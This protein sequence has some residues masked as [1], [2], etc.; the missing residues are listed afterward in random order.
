MKRVR[1]S[2]RGASPLHLLTALSLIALSGLAF[3]KHSGPPPDP[4]Q[5]LRPPEAQQS[6]IVRGY[7]AAAVPVPANTQ[8]DP[9]SR[10]KPVRPDTSGIAGR[11]RGDDRRAAR[12]DARTDPPAELKDIYLP[13]VS[14]FLEDP[15]A[16][17]R[18]EAG[19]TDLSG[20]FTLYA[21]APGRYRLCWKSGVYGDG[22]T[23]DLVSAGSESRFLSTVRIQLPPQ[24]DFV[25][26]SGRVTT[27]DGSTP[28]VFDPLLNINAFATVSLWDARAERVASVYVNNFGDYLIPHVPARQK[29]KLTAAIESAGS[30]RELWPE[31]RLE[32]APFHRLDLKIENR[33]PRLDPLVAFDAS[34]RRVQNAAPGSRINVR[35]NVRDDDG[36]PVSYTWFVEPGGGGLSSTTES[37]TL[38][39]LPDTPGRHNITVV[40]R[41]GK[42]GYDKSVLS[43]LVGNRGV[44]FTG[45]V[46]EPGGA[47][48]GNA[49]VE[50]VGNPAVETGPDGY[51]SAVVAEA[52]RYVFNVR[53]RGYALNSQIYDR[54]VTGGR[55]LL[56]PAK[57]VIIDPTREAV[58]NHER[59]QRDCPGPD[60]A[61]AGSG[62][63][64]DS[65]SEPQWQD[66]QG[67]A[68]DRPGGGADEFLA[69][70]GRCCRRKGRVSVTKFQRRD[71]QAER[72]PAVIPRTLQLRPCGPGVGVRIPAN[73][74]LDASGNPATAPFEAAISTVDLL[75][76]QQMPG[77]GS[78]Q[79][80]SGGG[81]LESFG[82]GALDLPPGFKLRD[83]ARATVTIPVD[84]S[85]LM[86]GPLP[87][88]VPFLTYDEVKGLWV[89]EGS[90]TLTTVAGAQSY[91]AT[92][93]HFSSFNAD[94]VFSNASCL[95]VFSQSLPGQYNLEVSA[96][97]GGT[98]APY[99]V[100]KPVDNTSSQEHV[101][102]NLPNNANVTL[103]PMTQGP[104]P[105]LL[106]YYVVNSGPP[107][108]PNNSPGVPPGP[109]YTSCQN[110]V[111]LKAGSAPDTP[112]GGEFL[113]GLGNVAG[114]NLG[115]DDL[116][117]ADP[118]GNALR[119]AIVAASR[120]YYSSVD[121]SN[122]R[123]TFDAFKTLHGFNLDP[124]GATPGEIVA[125]YANS[126]DLG[127]GRD[128]HCLKKAGG[129]VACYVTNYGTG[130]VNSHPGIGTSDQ[131]DAAA[132]AARATVGNSAEVATV[133]MEYSP[134][135]GAG[136]AKVVKFFVYK[137]GFPNAG[138]YERSISANLDGRGE[139]P[140]PQLCMI[141]HGGAIPSH[142]GG[143]PAFG[144]ATQVNLNARFVPFDHRLFTFPASPS[145]AAQEASIKA[146]NE[147][148]V[149]AAP[150]APSGDAIKEVVAGL[151]NNGAASQQILNF[152]VPGWQTGASANL[153]NQSD[154]YQKVVANGCRTC[155][156]AQPFD[157]L[158]FNTSA[159]FLR[160]VDIG[161]PN[162]NLMLGTA[163]LR[164]CGDY[165]MPHAFRTHE[166][167]WQKYTAID[168]TLLQ[169]LMPER[170]Q[171][172]GDGVPN[173][174]TGP[175]QQ[176]NWKA[177][178]C[179][180]FVSNLAA[181]PSNF[182]QQSI[183]PIFNGKCIYCHAGGFPA[184]GLN[185]SE[186]SPPDSP[187][188][189]WQQLLDGRVVPGNDNG[190]LLVQRITATGGTRMPPG[191]WR[192]PEKPPDPPNGSLPCLL[193]PDVDRI[194]AWI[195]SGAN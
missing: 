31:A 179:T 36:D 178:L 162:N 110:F 148:I 176:R 163:Q 50:I 136:P 168:P 115:F 62:A 165:T 102:Y 146:L 101:I 5:T 20:R 67:R 164:A 144:N 78:V 174:F 96:P 35:S 49:R 154:F 192:A 1:L 44:P 59:G 145:K 195:R 60:S 82:A 194:K 57:I 122:L 58:I 119:D 23:D 14:V 170:L 189:S 184:G 7:L 160:R 24:K 190:S 153:P 134:I 156:T 99:V 135:E 86:G 158:K 185:L 140:V 124:N 118:T 53:K 55:W 143:V 69:T 132:A 28:R 52:D 42:G 111:V 30:S 131:D 137:K 167:F 10:R 166:I 95:R 64:G 133:A 65:I 74:I 12:T 73:S 29:I 172:F 98:G 26:M 103:A 19:Q 17:L 157:Q 33:R 100:T 47:P 51:F 130:Y 191:C 2:Q 161:D 138:S 63:A 41:D 83:G 149:D 66:G 150:P 85:R 186:A 187:Q 71:E 123:T 180:S 11:R 112:F 43:V 68:V 104:N 4:A 9:D 13:G 21:P 27:A 126:G 40:A 16:S 25:L 56:H 22:C 87:P 139:R 121:P 89:E 70:G 80:A 15:Q 81:R 128:M 129:D 105:Q 169:F 8:R 39:T 90:M 155:H 92:T 18:S 91:V 171:S 107:Q 32:R 88:A 183:Q 61:A 116:T 72:P 181:Q 173:I 37:A 108:N 46:V 6:N 106:G 75:S 38:W 147:Q 94:N 159:R 97:V 120:N 109:P 127:F 45:V 125:Q 84:R 142:A 93:S 117:I 141:C 113:H 114:L 193:Q 54:G 79:R 151:Y 77:D 76:P 175:A 188:S 177:E 48:V 34:N 3:F 182:Y 152:D